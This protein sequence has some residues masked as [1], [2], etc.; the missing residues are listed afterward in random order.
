MTAVITPNAVQYFKRYRMELDLVAPLPAASALPE[1]FAWV[2]WEDRLLETHAEV[3]Y[4]CFRNELDGVVFPNLCNRAGCTRLMREIANRPGFRP[5]S[6]W[7]IARG[8][9]YVGTVQGIADRVGNGSIQNLGVVP[10]QR[11]R[12][13]GLALL[14]QALHGFR[15]TG[16]A[17]A[18]LEVTAQNDTAVRLYRQ[19][20][21]R[22]RKTLYKVADTDTFR[23]EPAGESQWT[24]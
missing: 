12:G 2:P 9:E 22:F 24:L 13:L 4:Q 18:T 16:L 19:I 10:G 6:T 14:L 1:G 15:R 21:F 23:L 20:G 17:R 7:L 8:E 11:G 3:K 5:E